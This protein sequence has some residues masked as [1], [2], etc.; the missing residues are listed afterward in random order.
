MSLPRK[1]ERFEELREDQYS[2]AVENGVLDVY[3]SEIMDINEGGVITSLTRDTLS[4]IKGTRI[5][6]LF[7]GRWEKRLPRPRRSSDLK[8][9]EQV[10]Y[11]CLASLMFPWTAHK[12]AFLDIG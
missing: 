4:Q 9:V 8:L 11:V 10:K 2:F 3:G 1:H 6:A 12:R 7:R 5:E